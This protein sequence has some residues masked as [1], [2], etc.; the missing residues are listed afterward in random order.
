M[1]QKVRGV[2]SG[3]TRRFK[4]VSRSLSP[5]AE[6]AQGVCQD[7]AFPSHV[8]EGLTLGAVTSGQEYFQIRNEHI[9]AGPGAVYVVPPDTMHGGHS[10][11]RG[12]W[13]YVSLYI[14][15]DAVARLFE[16]DAGLL[17]RNWAPIVQD[18]S[19]AREFRRSLGEMVYH[20]ERLSADIALMEIVSMLCEA[21][22]YASTPLAAVLQIK[23]RQLNKVR[24]FIDAHFQADI[25]LEELANVAG[26]S[27]QHLIAMFKKHFGGTPYAYLVARRL[28]AARKRML[29]GEPLALVA[30]ECGF[31]DQSHLNRHFVRVFGQS[32]A[33]Y[34]RSIAA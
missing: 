8:H 15:P 30:T 9:P 27:R 10:Y 34:A 23:D 33:A 31:C 24:D 16:D 11:Q 18:T 7:F 12:S 28:A 4:S 17:D 22:I 13:N 26:W 14:T 21:S 32:P 5:G 1:G 3:R 19:V 29:A 2:Q 20:P 25:S 6:I